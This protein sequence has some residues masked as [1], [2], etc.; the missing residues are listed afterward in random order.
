M[1]GSATDRGQAPSVPA[2]ERGTRVALIFALAAERLSA[3]YEHGQWLTEGQG[4]SLAS[5]WLARTKRNLPLGERKHLSA[6]SDQLARQIGGT[7]SREAGLYTTHEMMESLDPN[8]HSDLGLSLMA[9]CERLLN[10]SP[11][12]ET[13][14]LPSK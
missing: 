8:H 4:A 13:D 2:T 10:G 7:L 6:L 11:E 5:E 1:N 9:E 14:G 3:Y 12:E